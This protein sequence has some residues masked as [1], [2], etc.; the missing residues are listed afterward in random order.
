LSRKPPDRIGRY[1]LIRRIGRGGSGDVYL[2]RLEA[3]GGVRRLAAIKI[4][5]HLGDDPRQH[6]ALLAEARL[7]ALLCH[8]NIAQVLDAGVDNGLSWFAMEFV[9]GLSFYELMDVGAGQIPPW[10][11]ARIVADACAAVHALHEATDEQGT[12]LNVVHR[13]VTPHNLLVSW[14]GNVKLV[15]L[16]VAHSALRAS[17]TKTGVVKGKLGYMSPEQA[18]GAA[19]DRRCDVFAL[20]VQL[21]EALAGRRLFRQ[22]NDSETLASIVRGDIPPLKDMADIPAPL[23]AVAAGALMIDPAARIAT[24]FE[25]Q[26]ALDAALGTAGVVI[27][28]GDVARFLAHVAPERVREHVRWLHEA[29]NGPEGIVL[30]GALSVLP[31]SRGSVSTRRR[32]R[33]NR[34]TFAAMAVVLAAASGLVISRPAADRPPSAKRETTAPPPASPPP[35][36]NV[37]I[38]PPT[39]PGPLP[40]PEVGPERK[41]GPPRSTTRRTARAPAGVG[42]L[43]VSASPTWATITLDGKPAGTTPTVI[44]DLAEG[45]YTVAALPL[46]KGPPIRRQVTVVAGNTAQVGFEFEEP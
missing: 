7:G 13:D 22:Q 44:S 18:S 31:P 21:W 35:A 42:K 41:P 29:Q 20:G 11:A 5:F 1:R 38:A 40:D 6:E 27:G 3:V 37:A 36:V 32:R 26:R 14:D 8:P 30:D 19:V 43:Y 24:A 4:L 2:A 12:A 39:T 23:A 45:R 33:S 34:L 15:D 28:S 16:G 25:M 46:G 9:P 10:I 17:V